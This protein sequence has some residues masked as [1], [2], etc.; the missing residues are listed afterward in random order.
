MFESIYI[1]TIVILSY[2]Y[3]IQC[4]RPTIV[5]VILITE[6]HYS[7]SQTLDVILITEDHYSWSQTLDVILITEDHYSWS[8]TL[9]VILIN[10]SDPQL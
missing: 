10:Y 4:L 5:I 9:D 3:N 2:E 1:T 6:D 8:Q 7:W